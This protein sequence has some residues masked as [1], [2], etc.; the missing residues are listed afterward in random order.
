MPLDIGADKCRVQDVRDP[1]GDHHQRPVSP[2]RQL[3]PVELLGYT[4]ANLSLFP[5]RFRPR[6]TLRL[7]FEARQDLA[8]LLGF[9]RLAELR[10]LC[11]QL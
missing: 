3:V 11:N 4:Y 5:D 7:L 6:L 2:G 10:G 8:K 9:L 1:V